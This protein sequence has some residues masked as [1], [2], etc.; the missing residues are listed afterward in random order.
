ME[1]SQQEVTIFLSES[2]KIENEPGAEALMTSLNAWNHIKKLDKLTIEDLL[3]CHLLI[4]SGIRPDIAGKF[5][6][7]DVYVGGAKGY[8]PHAIDK[9][10]RQWIFHINNEI[11]CTVDMI[12]E[13]HIWFEIIHPFVDG[14]GRI[15]RMVLLWQRQKSGLPFIIIKADTKHQYYY[16][17]F[18]EARMIGKYK[19]KGN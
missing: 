18:I 11:V 5:R 4:M 6:T 1:Y 3:T 12:K 19:Y 16:P 8:P 13:T 17:C 2:N 10:V 9:A 15:G 7:I 14:N